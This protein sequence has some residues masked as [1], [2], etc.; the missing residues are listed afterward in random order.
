MQIQ[1]IKRLLVIDQDSLGESF[2]KQALN[3]TGYQVMKVNSSQEA[4]HSSQ[5]W[6]PD[7]I[8][9]NVMQPST[10]G[11]KLCEKIR[12]Y[13]QVPILVV[14]AI[15]DPNAIAHWLDAGA[16]DYITR[17]YSSDILVAHL[18][19]LTRRFASEHYLPQHPVN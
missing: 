4:I 12:E 7:I 13:T 10:N 18:Q 14:A 11:W 16:D 1:S 17:P 2:L 3:P 6:T 19:K 15:A 8:I 9:I 5:D